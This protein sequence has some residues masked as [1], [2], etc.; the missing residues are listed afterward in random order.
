MNSET[1]LKFPIDIVPKAGSLHALNEHVR[2]IRMPL[3]MSLNH[4][5]LWALGL[6]DNLTLVDTGMHLDDTKNAWKNLIQSENLTINDVVVTHMHPDHIGMAGWF[7]EKYNTSFSMSR[8]DYLQ[9]RMLSA[10]T[11]DIVPHDAIDF[12]TK[13]GMTEDQITSFIKKFGF[14]GSIIHPL[15]HSYTRLKEHDHIDVNG[16]KWVAIEGQGHTL[17]HLCFFSEELN[18][19]ISGDQL[20]PTISSH[21]G[22]FPTEPDAN[23]VEDWISSCHKLIGVLP[24]DVL[25]LPAHGRPFLGAHKR[26]TALINHHETSL[27]KLYD[28]LKEP[29]RAIDVFDILFKRE[30]DDGNLIMATGESL[31][32]LNCL[33][34]RNQAVKYVE[35]NQCW[36][37]QK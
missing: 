20:L 36:Y 25:V 2:W 15:P 5:N 6:Q 17:E 27:S 23:P 33:I 29:K 1:K 13:A 30:I 28:A 21:V 12:Y 26:L 35:N 7:V 4:I 14:F 31:G 34:H 16:I 3:P 18:M 22:I 19:F 32:H 8:T 11:G 10:D 24:E 37:E 9:C